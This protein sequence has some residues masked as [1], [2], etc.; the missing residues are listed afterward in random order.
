MVLWTAA[1][2]LIVESVLGQAVEPVV[3][4]HKTGLSPVA[5]IVSATFWTW[6][7]GPIGLILATPLTVCLVVLGRHVDRFKFIDVMLGDQ[8]PLTPPELAY[9]R[10]LAGD[11]DEAAE[12][13]E[14]FLQG[15]P[16]LTYYDKVVVEA[17]RLAQEDSDRGCSMRVEWF[18]YVT[19]FLRSWM[20][21]AHIKTKS[22]RRTRPSMIKKSEVRLHTSHRPKNPSQETI[23]K[24]QNTGAL[25][26]LCYAYLDSASLMRPTRR[27]L[28]RRSKGRELLSAPRPAT[29]FRSPVSL[30]WTQLVWSCCAYAICPP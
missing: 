1:L 7:W 23:E 28:R 13:A 12:Q 17:L 26:S 8:P 24:S 20:I 29:H 15:A 27:L 30:L 25:A 9:Q 18:G 21:L 22:I 14:E 19:P 11:S 16:L 6:L 2:F 10:M 4:G 3:F 5:I